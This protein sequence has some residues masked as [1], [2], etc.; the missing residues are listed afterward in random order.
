[1]Y[2]WMC[3]MILW[4]CNVIFFVFV[5]F[6]FVV[7]VYGAK[8]NALMSSHNALMSSKTSASVYCS[9]TPFYS[10]FM[11]NNTVNAHS[12]SAMSYC[13]VRLCSDLRFVVLIVSL[14]C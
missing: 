13:L 2:F 9:T 8:H 11:F 12:S 5:F 4:W 7:G 10:I 3:K 14:F 1:M 6:S